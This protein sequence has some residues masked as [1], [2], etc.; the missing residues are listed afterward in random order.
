MAF[1]GEGHRPIVHIEILIAVLTFGLSPFVQ[2]QKIADLGFAAFFPQIQPILGRLRRFTEQIDP[3]IVAVQVNLHKITAGH[4]R[5]PHFFCQEEHTVIPK[6]GFFPGVGDQR[7]VLFSARTCTQQIDLQIQLQLIGFF[8]AEIPGGISSAP[9][10]AAQRRQVVCSVGT[11]A[12]GQSHGQIIL[13]IRNLLPFFGFDA[14]N[15]KNQGVTFL[16]QIGKLPAVAGAKQKKQSEH[17]QRYS[18]NLCFFHH[19]SILESR[20]VHTPLPDSSSNF[21]PEKGVNLAVGL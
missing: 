19:F 5:N 2:L 15:R 11:A 9:D 8:L 16:F 14:Q 13:P 21:F 20:A 18:E 7:P 12:D 6:H 3:D 17:Q 10:A 4:R 1:H